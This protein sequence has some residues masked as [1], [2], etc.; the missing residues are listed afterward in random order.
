MVLL[1][2]ENAEMCERE[3]WNRGIS[4][5]YRKA[6]RNVPPRQFDAVHEPLVEDEL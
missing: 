5:K 3:S 1:N 6:R 4:E 2:R